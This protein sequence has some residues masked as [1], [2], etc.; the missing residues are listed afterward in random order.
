MD[1]IVT[2]ED[3]RMQLGS[4]FTCGVSWAEDH[5]SLDC[6]ECGGYSM[7]RPCPLCEGSCGATWKRDFAMVIK[8][9]SEFMCIRFINLPLR[10]SLSVSCYSLT[11]RAMRGG[12]AAVRRRTQTRS[13]SPRCRT[14]VQ[15]SLECWPMEERPYPREITPAR[16]LAS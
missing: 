8:C 6:S 11:R 5:V 4:C 16:L 2:I 9:Y 13:L 1:N 14:A 3:L 7:E 12:W 15:I 10:L